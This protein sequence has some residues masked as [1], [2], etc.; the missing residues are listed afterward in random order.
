MAKEEEGDMGSIDF[1]LHYKS[2]GLVILL[3]LTTNC[4]LTTSSAWVADAP[5]TPKTPLLKQEG[6]HGSKPWRQPLAEMQEEA[7]KALLS[8]TTGLQQLACNSVSDPQC[9]GKS[10]IC[11]DNCNNTTFCH[12]IEMDL[13]RN[14]L[15]GPIPPSLVQLQSLSVLDLSDNS[16]GGNLPPFQM[17]SLLYMYLSKNKLDGPI[18]K[19]FV[20]L[21]S[22]VNLDLSSN[23]FESQIPPELGAL[24]NLSRLD[25]SDNQ[26][27][28][29]IPPQLGNLTNLLA[30]IL[31]ANYLVGELPSSFMRLVNLTVLTLRNCSLRGPIP[32]Y[33]WELQ[34]LVYLFLRKNKLNGILPA[35]LVALA[36]TRNVTSSHRY[37]DVSEN[38]FTLTTSVSDALPNQDV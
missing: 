2:V 1:K 25:V 15:R 21:T 10:I 12:V 32:N 19:S 30:L 14:R 37:V 29:S 24:K 31:R 4:V 13:S 9:D 36:N 35:W 38:N 7:I 16:L 5:A 23:C 6:G 11:D 28:G 34:Y 26:L 17:K 8:L 33:I 18:P 3:L 27:S 20:N 22:L